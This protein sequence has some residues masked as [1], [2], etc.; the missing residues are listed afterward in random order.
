M[1]PINEKAITLRQ[2]ATLSQ[3]AT[4]AAQRSQQDQLSTQHHRSKVNGLGMWSAWERNF[5]NKLKACLD[6]VD[7]AVDAALWDSDDEEDEEEDNE[8]R[9][10]KSLTQM[11]RWKKQ[12]GRI[13]IST[14]KHRLAMC[15]YDDDENNGEGEN[16]NGSE[17]SRA[18]PPSLI[19]HDVL[20]NGGVGGRESNANKMNGN[21]GK[22]GDKTG[23]ATGDDDNDFVLIDDENTMCLHND[24]VHPVKELRKILDVYNSDKT[25]SAIG[26]NGV[27][28]KQ[29]AAAMSDLSIVIT[30]RIDEE[31]LMMNYGDDDD[32]EN[33]TPR[34]RK[35]L[36]SIGVL[37]K[38]M[39]SS[40]NCVIPSWTLPIEFYIDEHNEKKKKKQDNGDSGTG[41][42]EYM[43]ETCRPV[44]LRELANIT[45]HNALLGKTMK[46]YGGAALQNRRK[47]GIQRLAKHIELM[48]TSSKTKGTKSIKAPHPHQYLMILH[49]FG[50]HQPNS[51]REKDNNSAKAAVVK[52]RNELDDLLR[53]LADE[54]P[55]TY[56]HIPPAPYFRIK[57]NRE[58]LKFQY[59]ERHLVELHQIPLIIDRK[60]DFRTSED[61]LIPENPDDCYQ[62][63]VSIGFDPS[64]ANPQGSASHH[65]TNS[66]IGGQS[67]SLLIFSRISGRLFLKHDD[68]RGILRLTNSGTN[69]CQGL[70]VIV[71]DYEGHLPLTPTKE[72]LAFGLEDYGK[73]HERNLYAWLGAL[74]NVYWTHFFTLF[75]TKT[76]LGNAVRAKMH[77]VIQ[78]EQAEAKDLPTLRDGSFSSVEKLYF[79]RE[80]VKG[81]IRPY[82][83]DDTTWT[84][85]PHTLVK[86]MEK[87]TPKLK[88][89]K[90]TPK[91]R[92]AT[93]TTLLAGLDGYDSDGNDLME[94]APPSSVFDS[95]S[96]PQDSD[97]NPMRE[98]LDGRPVRASSKPQRFDEIH[99]SFSVTRKKRMKTTTKDDK[100][101]DAAL[102]KKLKDVR[103]ELK[104][105]QAELN[106]SKATCD[107]LQIQLEERGQAK[108]EERRKLR[109]LRVALNTAEAAHKA[110]LEGI[111]KDHAAKVEALMA[112]I[113]ELEGRKEVEVEEDST[114][115]LI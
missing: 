62:V 57:I 104:E 114:S 46:E 95:A 13:N 30:T 5:S 17:T 110:E 90:S 14:E 76:A 36:I 92:R 111:K 91:K 44:L 59:W 63:K 56:L 112:R 16:S 99:E 27:G 97:G 34:V 37:S 3:D 6:L 28:V 51:K 10:G 78:L 7:N 26:E 73:I 29:A 55:K 45:A 23:D 53:D 8:N 85:G 82:K 89:K 50:K 41:V 70:T 20:G 75:K 77:D 88:P 68:A 61:W 4:P 79:S 71:D 9:P 80:R 24:C 84:L 52:A 35:C 94:G 18:K 106:A 38:K 98:R 11:E 64:R 72:S 32:D 42:S 58:T 115:F 19:I 21:A 109:E 69:F 12:S 54:M 40:D 67:C 25:D 22:D 86:L 66:F 87:K 43:G 60:N 113:G 39:Q 105:T 1:D 48:V 65:N 93:E 101:G 103:M 49:K 47:Y 100:G 96:G 83:S 15:D 102:K 107:D 108:S 81:S 74:A 2:D 33:S 31:P